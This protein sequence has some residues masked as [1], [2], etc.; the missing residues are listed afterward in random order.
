MKDDIAEAV[1][2]RVK[3]PVLG[4]VVLAFVAINWRELSLLIFSPSPLVYKL[5]LFDETTTA[6][7]L[8]VLPSFAGIAYVVITPWL[9]VFSVAV[10]GYPVRLRRKLLDDAQQEVELRK[11]E[12]EQ[13]R[14]E[15]LANREK[16]V[17][18]RAK[19]DAD[20]SEIDDEEVR[21]KAESD[22]KWLRGAY[23]DTN[24]RTQQIQL[25]MSILKELVTI[26][27]TTR[28]E[29]P[30]PESSTFSKHLVKLVGYEELMKTRPD[31]KVRSG[32]AEVAREIGEELNSFGKHK[33]GR[34]AFELADLLLE[35]FP[36]RYKAL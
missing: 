6:W 24:E 22:L 1:K 34:R 4:Y 20:V 16:E 12:Y 11:Q 27:E 36:R 25:G 13:L 8:F 7:G 33:L 2:E 3:S 35:G 14:T 29:L 5:A 28:L 9:H 17:I 10:S 30:A 23:K 18:D 31:F 15:A 21:T 19:R 32:L 26:I